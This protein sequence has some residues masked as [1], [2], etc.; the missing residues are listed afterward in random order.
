MQVL[1]P[2]RRLGFTRADEGPPDRALRE[3]RLP[4]CVVAEGRPAAAWSAAWSDG[5]ARVAGRRP[6]SEDMPM[7]LRGYAET[8]GAAA[9]GAA[10]AHEGQDLGAA[11]DDLAPRRPSV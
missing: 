10:D 5:A 7:V 1:R 3:A 4:R 9:F 11:P 6:V 2:G 8:I